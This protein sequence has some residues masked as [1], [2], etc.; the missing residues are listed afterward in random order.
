[1]DCK[2]I[3]KGLVFG[4]CQCLAHP[5]IQ[6]MICMIIFSTVSQLKSCK[7]KL[8]CDSSPLGMN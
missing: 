2:K 4:G 5:L 6:Y 1:M 7:G 8:H 3:K